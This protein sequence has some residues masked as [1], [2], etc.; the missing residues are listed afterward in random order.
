MLLFH[1]SGVTLVLLI[2]CLVSLFLPPDANFPD[3][4]TV[5]GLEVTGICRTYKAHTHV[6]L[7]KIDQ[8]NSCGYDI[9]SGYAFWADDGGDRYGPTLPL[10]RWTVVSECFGRGTSSTDS[11]TGYWLEGAVIGCDMKRATQHTARFWMAWGLFIGHNALRGVDNDG[12]RH[13]LKNHSNGPTSNDSAPVSG[14]NARTSGSR[15][16]VIY[17]NEFGDTDNNQSLP[18]AIGPQNGVV[19]E[20]LEDYIVE[21][22]ISVRSGSTSTDLNL[23]GRRMTYINNVRAAGGAASVSAPGLHNAGLPSGWNGPYYSNRD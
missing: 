19:S 5:A 12:I 17:K 22:N 14:T 15:Y 1:W 7:H 4:I 13:C 20:G 18:V 2:T 9:G 21:E 8:P 23:A 3:R 11:F 6:T 10:P 16:V